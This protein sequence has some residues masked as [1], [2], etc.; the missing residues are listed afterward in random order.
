MSTRHCHRDSGL[1]ATTRLHSRDAYQVDVI[2]QV[3]RD[4]LPACKS[5]KAPNRQ[6]NKCILWNQRLAL[7][8]WNKK[9]QKQSINLGDWTCIEMNILVGSAK[10]RTG[11]NTR[12][13]KTNKG[14]RRMRER[15]IELRVRSS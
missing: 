7:V 5:N 10:L 15:R 3:N 8:V 2:L 11:A 4:T 13:K 6:H 9:S 14:C 1:Y 12:V